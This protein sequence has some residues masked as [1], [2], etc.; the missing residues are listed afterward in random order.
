MAHEE[1]TAK[2]LN[3]I[4]ST[5]DNPIPVIYQSTRR[6]NRCLLYTSEIGRKETLVLAVSL[7]LGLGVEL[8]PDVLKQ[9]PEAIRL[10]R[11]TTKP[12]LILSVGP[13]NTA[14][15]LSLIHI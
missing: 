7:S 6:C 2:V 11:F 1:T 14:P 8:M 9:A 5:S 4:D 15:T 10:V 3:S 12:S 13:N